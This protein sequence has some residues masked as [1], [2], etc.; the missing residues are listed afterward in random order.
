MRRPSLPWKQRPTR[1]GSSYDRGGCGWLWWSRR[2]PTPTCE[3]TADDMV[4]ELETS[5]SAEHRA[6]YDKHIA[7]MKKFIPRSK[8]MA[9]PTSSVVAVVEA[10]L[11]RASTT[12]SICGRSR[13]QAFDVDHD[14][15]PL[16]HC[17]IRI[18]AGLPWRTYVGR[19]ERAPARPQTDQV[20]Q[21]GHAVRHPLAAGVGLDQ[22]PASGGRAHRRGRT[23]TAGGRTGCP[24]WWCDSNGTG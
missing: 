8:K 11:T 12:S 1:S 13:K 23:P 18:I 3:R 7:G 17:V 21:L 22:C 9:V 2:K 20:W 5:M 6:L 16:Q 24:R 10:A 14:K 15:Y 19:S 4:V